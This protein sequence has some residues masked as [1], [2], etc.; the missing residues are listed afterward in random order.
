MDEIMK[1]GIDWNLLGITKDLSDK[2][3]LLISADR[4]PLAV[5]PFHHDLLFQKLKAEGIADLTEAKI[6]SDHSFSDRRIRLIRTVLNWIERR[7]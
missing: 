3:L 2:S 5:Q 1:N 6:D 4:D 7:I